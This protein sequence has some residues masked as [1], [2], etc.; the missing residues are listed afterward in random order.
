[1]S[2]EQILEDIISFNTIIIHRHTRPDPDAYGSQGGLAEII[3]YTFPEKE[4]YVVGEEEETLH[5]MMRMDQIDDIKYSNALVIVCDTANTE[6]I[7]DSRYKMGS[8]LIKIDHHPNDDKYGDVLYVD[9]SSS[10]TSEIIYELYKAGKDSHSFKINKKAAELI[11]AGIVGD[12]GRFLFPS[13]T[14]KTFEIAAEL[15]RLGIDFPK[16]Y[17]NIYKSSEKVTR[18][19]GHILQNFELHASGMGVAK[20]TKELL[21]KFN[22]SPEEASNATSN[23]GE[24]IGI[25]AWA[26]FLEED[27]K[28]R[29]RL[30]SKGPVINKLASQFNG[31]GHPL[32]SGAVVF[33][34]YEADKLIEYLDNICLNN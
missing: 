10:S 25:K 27:D 34:W 28:I 15:V 21:N 16:I 33:N 1:M 11:F 20:V 26:I 24:V 3:K 14:S 9:T 4:V 19:N 8:K 22:I 17:D 31:G 5:F 6:R 30:R 13:S 29:V 23:L 32:A 7:S 2:I 12:T 18:L